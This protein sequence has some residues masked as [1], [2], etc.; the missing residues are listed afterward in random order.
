[1][2][3]DLLPYYDRELAILR[4]LAGEFAERHPKIAGRLSLGRDESQDPHVERMLQGVAFLAARVQKRLD[5]DYPE[6]SDGLLDL[7][8]Q[9]RVDDQVDRSLRVFVVDRLRKPLGDRLEL[10][11]LRRTRVRL[12]RHKR[13]REGRRGRRRHLRW[14]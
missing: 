4:S 1:M 11:Q 9:E 10:L 7:L 6:L 8:Y 14:E 3:D 13:R 12:Y 5:D 2:S